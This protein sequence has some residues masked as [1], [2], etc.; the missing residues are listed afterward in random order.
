[1]LLD[2]IAGIT[3]VD[4]RDRA[5][6]IL[7]AKYGK[8]E[9]ERWLMF[10]ER[11]VQRQSGHLR[12]SAGVHVPTS[13][14]V[15]NLS[16]ED[17]QEHGLAVSDILI[18]DDYLKSLYDICHFATH[19]QFPPPNDTDE[20]PAKFY[21]PFLNNGVRSTENAVSLLGHPGIGTQRC[22]THTRVLI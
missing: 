19:R 20:L 12:A 11:A 16:D 1:M 18:R 5:L 10:E 17:R 4:D 7:W 9:S 8:W 14:T 15:L 13:C 2:S 6:F 3:K 22:L 21:N